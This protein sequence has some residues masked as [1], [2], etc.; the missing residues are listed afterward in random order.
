MLFLTNPGSSTQQKA[1]VRPLI[2]HHVNHPKHL[3]T[4]LE[5]RTQILSEFI[6]FFKA[7]NHVMLKLMISTRVPKL[8]GCNGCKRFRIPVKL[9]RLLL[10]KYPWERGKTSLTSVLD[11]TVNNS[12]VRNQKC[13][14]F[15]AISPRSTL[16]GSGSTRQGPIY[17]S[18]RTL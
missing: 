10:D 3:G 8:R 7:Y 13:W 5:I 1:A 11:M 9:L 6:F 12:I 2:S 15:T 16:A 17:G 18:N 14:R 4:G